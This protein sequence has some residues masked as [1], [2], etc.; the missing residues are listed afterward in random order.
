MNIRDFTGV[1][2]IGGEATMRTPDPVPPGKLRLVVTYLEM[3]APPTSPAPPP[4]HN[5]R[6][7]LLRAERITVSYY[8]YLYNT[9]GE[10]CFWHIRRAM[11]DDELT[12]IIAHELVDIFVLYAGGVPAGFVELDRRPAPDIDI[13]FFGL[14]PEFI[15]QGFGRYLLG[16]AVAE[17]WRHQPRKLM[18]NTNNLDHPRAMPNY[19]RAGFVP[20]RQEIEVIDDPREIGLIPRHV[21]LR[22]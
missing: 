19:Q 5:R 18:V 22:G 6:V 10:A 12:A 21:P 17:A 16:W 13:A 2:V 4:P 3:T 7:A 14:V 20:M 11:T 15:G 8:R 9:V 1:T